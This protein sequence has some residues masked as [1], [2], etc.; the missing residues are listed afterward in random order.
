FVADVQRYLHDEP[1]QACPP[2]AWYRFRKFARRNKAVLVTATAVASAVLLTVAG[3]AASTVLT[4]GALQSEIQ[5]PK[6]LEK[7]VQREQQTLYFQRIKTAAREFAANNLGR[8][9][10]S[11]DQ[12]IPSPGQPD[13]RGWEWHY[14]K[15][16]RYQEPHDL[17]HPDVVLGVACRPNGLYLASGGLDGSVIVWDRQT[18]QAVC[19][20]KGR[21]QGHAKHVYGLAFSPDSRYLATGGED[22]KVIVWDLSSRSLLYTLPGHTATI[23]Q[24]AF[25]PDGQ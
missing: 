18:W 4:A 24:L 13:L 16:R 20:W 7:A 6:E 14:L 1:V 10:Q 11:L 8:A 19:T 15:R 22:C 23:R 5:A 25:S 12:C 9:E 21:D 17:P 3:P 2:S